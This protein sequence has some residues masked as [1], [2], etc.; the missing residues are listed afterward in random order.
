[1]KATNRH[2]VTF[3][4]PGTF[5]AESSSR[6]IG[7]WDTR[8]AVE[9]SEEIVERYNA[10]PYG[11][12]FETRACAPDVDDGQGGVIPGAQKTIKTSGLHFL[13]GKLETVDQIAKRNDPGEEILL[14]NLRINDW[15]I[16][17]VNTNSWKS[18]QPFEADSVVVGP[19]GSIV[20]RGDD[21]N[22]AEY[23]DRKIA[24]HRKELGL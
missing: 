15:P 10:R 7:E 11:F 23:R 18:V 13:G 21:P 12:R 3:Y 6:E 14:G 9:L 8:K 4:S 16:V 2:F 22:W 5:F 17:C 20:E 19:D 1:M 24:E